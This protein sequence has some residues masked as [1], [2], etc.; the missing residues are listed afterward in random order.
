MDHTCGARMVVTDD[1]AIEVE[2]DEL[3][4]TLGRQTVN[5]SSSIAPPGTRHHGARF[6]GHRTGHFIGEIKDH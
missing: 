5:R 2:T 3:A 4:H 1:L 6:K